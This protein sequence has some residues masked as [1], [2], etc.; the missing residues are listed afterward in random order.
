[1]HKEIRKICVVGAGNMGH[2]IAVCAAL[3]GY[4]VTCCD[5]KE[6][7]LRSAEAFADGYLPQRVS[8]GKL[9]QEEAETARG[10]M[11]FTS[12]MREAAGDADL[13]IEAATERLEL[14]RSLFAQL[15][16]IAPPHAILA[17]NS[18]FLVSSKVADAT[19]RPGKVCN[20]HFF[21]PALVM[22]L[23]EVVKGPHTE[24]ETAQACYEV[25]QRMGKEPV[26][27]QKEVYGFLVNSILN[28]INRQAFFLAD[29]GVATPQEID[30][31]VE[32]GLNHPMGPFRLMDL[33]G[34]DMN[35]YQRLE[36]YQETQDPEDAPWPLLTEKWAKGEWGRK[37]KRGFYEYE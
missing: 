11:E 36:R 27:L 21:N 9:T 2:Q 23:V 34:I 8:K 25:A 29:M 7:A 12:D 19:R 37:T 22:K 31:A 33:T 6:E 1:M 32:N 13:V 10:N 24:E 18:S 28:A 3:A 20:M 17:T 35:Y 4:R 5:V 15:D 16:Q 26:I 30:K 14:K